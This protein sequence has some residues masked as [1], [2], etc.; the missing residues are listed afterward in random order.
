MA[1]GCQENLTF[2]IFPMAFRRL[3]DGSL[4]VDEPIV[5]EWQLNSSM[6]PRF[7]MGARRNL[8]RRDHNSGVSWPS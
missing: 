4:M 2:L 8:S 3:R 6:R 1:F 5:S 7:L